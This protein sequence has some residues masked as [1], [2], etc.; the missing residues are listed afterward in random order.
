MQAPNSSMNGTTFPPQED[1]NV[2]LECVIL[3]FIILC[4]LFG[5]SLVCIAFATDRKL[6]T[7]TN[8]FVVSLAFSDIV[9]ALVV[10]PVYMSMQLSKFVL[11]DMILYT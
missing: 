4:I 5:N 2:I 7:T 1:M 3:T 8:C 10:I 6:Q 9:V 11:F